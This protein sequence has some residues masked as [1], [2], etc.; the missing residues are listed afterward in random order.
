M[1]GACTFL[2]ELDK[3]LKWIFQ[4]FHF[5][6]EMQ[7]CSNIEVEETNPIAYIFNIIFIT[8]VDFGCHFECYINQVGWN[9]RAKCI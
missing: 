4:S 7:M 3:N 6:I 2:I 9:F 1:K 5:R 8:L